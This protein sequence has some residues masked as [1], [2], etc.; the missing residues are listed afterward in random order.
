MF[1]GEL[2]SLFS[3]TESKYIISH[4][5]DYAKTMSKAKSLTST[6][7]ADFSIFVEIIGNLFPYVVERMK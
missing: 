6:L 7:F 5:E 2:I 1:V 3:S 4:K